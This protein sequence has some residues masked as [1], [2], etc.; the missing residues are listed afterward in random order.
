M[1]PE[2]VNARSDA[3]AERKFTWQL[4]ADAATE[5]PL[6]LEVT[7]GGHVAARAAL[8]MPFLAGTFDGRRIRLY[9]DGQLAGVMDRPG[10]LKP[11]PS[12]LCLGNYALNHK[13]H[14]LGLLDEVQLYD[15]ALADDEIRE[16]SRREK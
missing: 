2:I 3:E 11:C 1:S 10:P 12:P 6:Q 9:V 16:L 15:R 13:A 8:D 5:A 4:E 14:F 7:V